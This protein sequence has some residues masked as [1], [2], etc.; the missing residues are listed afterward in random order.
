MHPAAKSTRE[1]ALPHITVL[2]QLPNRAGNIYQV[3]IGM[4][5][6]VSLYVAGE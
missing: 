1:A 4:Q 5:S 6:E 2:S 3:H